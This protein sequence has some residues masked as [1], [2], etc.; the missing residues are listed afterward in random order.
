M[1]CLLNSLPVFETLSMQTC[2]QVM[3]TLDNLAIQSQ[4]ANT[5]STFEELFAY[6]I[7]PVVNEND[8]VAVEELHFGDNDTLS[9]KVRLRIVELSL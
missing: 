8:T 4:F 1:K 2:A 7:V 5:A 9:A 6:G 3:L